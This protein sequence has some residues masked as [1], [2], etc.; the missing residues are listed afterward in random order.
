MP[1]LSD[2]LPSGHIEDCL[3]A[4]CLLEATARKPGNVHP[5]ASFVDLTYEDFRVAA[6]AAAPLIAQAESAG[7]GRTVWLA[8]NATRAVARSNVNLGIV[9]LLA[10]LTAVPAGKTLGDGLPGVLQGL[11]VADA[12]HVY[13]AIRLAQPG[14]LG[15][16]SQ[17]DVADEP[18]GTLLEVMALAADRD[19][20]A[21]QY[22]HN[23]VDVLEVGMPRLARHADFAT[24]WE[25]PI[26]GCH[27]ELLS[28]IPDS[29]I[30]RKCG[31]AVAGEASDRARQVL[32]AGWPLASGSTDALGDFDRWLRAD[33]N[34]RNPGTTADL[35]AACL[36]A[37][38]RERLI[39]IPEWTRLTNR[40]TGKSSP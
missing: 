37:A 39:P 20:V 28:R 16:A 17:Q 31:W 23:F 34:R 10:P 5:Q 13:R 6:V 3:R 21:Y 19:R 9:L 24:D 18:T 7:V 26:I 1:A 36:F 40:P 22:S 11:T 8:I 25:L 33:G 27:L 4:A 38:M 2:A 30:A 14:G 15:D 12:R 35:V 29:L 32:D